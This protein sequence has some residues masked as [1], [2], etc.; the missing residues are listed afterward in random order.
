MRSGRT[1]RVPRLPRCGGRLQLEGAEGNFRATSVRSR[2]HRRP[3]AQSVRARKLEVHAFAVDKDEV[4]HTLFSHDLAN[5][6]VR[7]EAS[8]PGRRRQEQ[9]IGSYLHRIPEQ[10]RHEELGRHETESERQRGPQMAP[11]REPETRTPYDDGE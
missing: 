2:V 8:P 6:A 10:P 11:T 5:V 3:G 9:P 4:H 1:R 7:D